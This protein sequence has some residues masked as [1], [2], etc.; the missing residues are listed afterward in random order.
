MRT[1]LTVLAC[2]VGLTWPVTGAAATTTAGGDGPRHD[3]I[4][5][6]AGFEGEGV[7]VGAG[8]TFYAGSLADGRIARGDLRAGT[9]EVFV[10]NPLLAPAV[11]LK[12]DLR[13]GLLWVA[14]GPTG[15]VAIYHLA[16]GAPVEAL[17]LSTADS[18]INDVVVTE[19][20]AY[21]TN[22]LSPEIYRIPVSPRGRIGE[23][24]TIALRGP[25][26]Q[27]V[28]GFN[29]NGIAATSDGATLILVNSARGQLYTVDPG[30]GDSA[31]IE[32]DGSSVPTGDGLLLT[33]RGLFVLQNGAQPGIPN[34][35]VVIRLSSDLSEGRV[36]DRI[37]SPLFETA[38]TLAKRGDILVAVNAQFAGAPIDP[39]SEVVLIELD[40]D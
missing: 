23:P 30:T 34:R 33:S 37:T 9:S 36:V 28:P 17:T 29:I 4:D 18:F 35:I 1:R 16:T 11:G 31:R 19:D 27:F 14:G 3:T 5:L 25:A 8:T 32:L 24:E 21:L 10:S 12:A 22:S 15:Q 6:P 13:H 2:V 26:G 40:D 7:A 38:T 39:E 20:A